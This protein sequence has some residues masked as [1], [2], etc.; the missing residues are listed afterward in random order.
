MAKLDPHSS[1]SRAS[2]S[3][4]AL[5]LWQLVE[6]SSTSRAPGSTSP[7]GAT[8]T[9]AKELTADDFGMDNRHLKLEVARRIKEACL[10][11]Y[12]PLP[13]PA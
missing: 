6:A 3:C 12:S 5:Q 13:K 8:P 1:R 10:A 4:I 2:S 9:A 11:H 7:A